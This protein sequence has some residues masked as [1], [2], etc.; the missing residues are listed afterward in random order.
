MDVLACVTAGKPVLDP[1]E[2]TRHLRGA[3]PHKKEQRRQPAP[4][5]VQSGT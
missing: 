1:V 3:V 2:E 5:I 4:P